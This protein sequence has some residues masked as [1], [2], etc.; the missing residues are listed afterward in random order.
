MDIVTFTALYSFIEPV[1]SS[2]K[3]EEYEWLFIFIT[4]LLSKE[5]RAVKIPKMFK[6]SRNVGGRKA[7]LCIC[8]QWSGICFWPASRKILYSAAIIARFLFP[9]HSSR[10]ANTVV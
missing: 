2:L 1:H 5:N 8:K 6:L 3:G 4:K 10:R 9:Y 7:H